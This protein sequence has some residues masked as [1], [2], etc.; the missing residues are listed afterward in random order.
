MKCI[1]CNERLVEIYKVSLCKRC[2]L[3]EW[4]I[5]NGFTS[6]KPTKKSKDNEIESYV[7]F[8]KAENNLVKIGK[9]IDPER[10]MSSLQTGSSCELEIIAVITGSHLLEGAIHKHLEEEHH[11]GEWYFHTQ[12]VDDLL[13]SLGLL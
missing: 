10:R 1:K 8:I 2:Y 11:H 7:Y 6:R 4:N 13:K 12:K 9:S 5:K 3:Q